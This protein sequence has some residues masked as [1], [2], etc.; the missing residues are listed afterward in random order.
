MRPTFLNSFLDE[1]EEKD[2][3]NVSSIS[4]VL[5]TM[6]GSFPAKQGY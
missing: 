5:V 4:F 1:F 6:I 3:S 2:E